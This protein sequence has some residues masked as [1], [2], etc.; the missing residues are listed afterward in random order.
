MFYLSSHE[1]IIGEH[2][3]KSGSSDWLALI[4]FCQIITIS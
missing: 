2:R 1:E 3:D 4:D